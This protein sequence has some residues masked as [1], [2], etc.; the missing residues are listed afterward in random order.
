[1]NQHRAVQPD[2]T[3][4]MADMKID[5]PFNIRNYIEDRRWLHSMSTSGFTLV[6]NKTPFG[7]E[8]FDSTY[9]EEWQ[10]LYKLRHMVWIDPIVLNA[11]LY[12]NSDNRWSEIKLPDARGVWKKARVYGLVYGATFAR[13]RLMNKSLLS[14][15]R[16]DREFT[17]EEMA[18]L[19]TWFDGFLTE[20]DNSLDL[21]EKEIEVIRLLARDMNIEEV[22]KNLSLT[23]SA[24]KTRLRQA[25]TKAGCKNNTGLIAKA[26]QAQLL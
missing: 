8:Y 18:A 13:T 3:P 10:M 1:M 17:D 15:A 6:A 19:S 26:S 2:F 24:V 22:A 23:Q 14:V 11:M 12:G 25:R 21:T 16:D 5:Q 7:V 4:T 9:P 20:V